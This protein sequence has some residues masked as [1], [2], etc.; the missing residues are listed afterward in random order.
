MRR[1]PILSESDAFGVTLTITAVTVVAVLVGWL[2]SSLVG[3]VVLVVLAGVAF[4]VYM[5]RPE[6]RRRR[7]L[8]IAARE[9]HP[10]SPHGRRHVLVVANEALEGERLAE[11]MRHLD[12]KTVVFNILAPV[13]ASRTHL[14][15][16]DLDAETE[17]AHRRLARSISWARAQGFAVHGAVGEASPTTAIED[18]LRLHGAEQV[19]I[20]TGHKDRWQERNELERVRQE[21]DVPVHEIT[22]ER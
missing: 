11:R 8:R 12:A 18:E 2:I 4:V 13:L 17:D 6:H 15:L 9:P 16:T 5:G 20:F 3:I 7:P 10:L 14:A 1:N 21:L 19:I 22:A